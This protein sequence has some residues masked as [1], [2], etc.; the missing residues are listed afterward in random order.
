[1]LEKNLKLLLLLERGGR[2]I[3]SLKIGRNASIK[4][5][6]MNNSVCTRSPKKEWVPKLKETATP[7]LKV[8]SGEQEND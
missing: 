4:Q 3:P 1:V 6:L 2:T 7:A 8:D 5:R